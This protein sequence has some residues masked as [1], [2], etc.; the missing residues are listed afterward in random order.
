MAGS[1]L[2]DLSELRIISLAQQGDSSAFEWLYNRYKRRIYFLCNRMVNDRDAAEDLTQETFM[3]VYR[4]LNTFRGD[5][6]FGTWLHR[7]AVNIVLMSVRRGRSRVSEISFE[8]GSDHSYEEAP[9]EKFMAV[10][11][12]RLS[13]ALDRVTIE[14]A[15]TCLPPGYA[16]VFLMHDV[17]GYQHNEIADVL[18]CSVG[19]TKSQLH[20]ARL[21]LRRCICGQLQGRGSNSSLRHQERKNA[22]SR[23]VLLLGS[24]LELL[25]RRCRVLRKNKLQ[26]MSANVASNLQQILATHRC[27]LVLVCE[28]LGLRQSRQ[29]ARSLMKKLSSTPFILLAELKHGADLTNPHSIVELVQRHFDWSGTVAA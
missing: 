22:A 26:A 4:R 14:R 18:N 20:K 19:N 29:I 16:I 3:Q 28:R 11:D 23:R 9:F 2:D 6:A 1:A 25:R 8:Q 12:H 21:K 17:Q 5:S 13:A 24:D 10:R 27:D 7:I 15:M